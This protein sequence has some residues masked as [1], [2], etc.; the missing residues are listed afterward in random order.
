M[1]LQEF[2]QKEGRV[3]LKTEKIFSYLN[4]DKRSNFSKR[5]IQLEID[6]NSSKRRYEPVH[7]S[8]TISMADFRILNSTVSSLD[9]IFK[10]LTIGLLSKYPA[11]YF[12][13]MVNDETKCI[14]EN[15]LHLIACNRN[16]TSLEERAISDIHNYLQVIFNEANDL[17]SKINETTFTKEISSI[18]LVNQ[19]TKKLD[20]I[21]YKDRCT[22]EYAHALFNSDLKQLEL[23]TIVNIN[24]NTI[25][26]TKPIQQDQKV[27][28]EKP[29]II[30]GTLEVESRTSRRIHAKGFYIDANKVT[31]KPFN[32]MLFC[33]GTGDQ[34]EQF[35]ELFRLIDTELS[36]RELT[37]IVKSKQSYVC[38]EG[39][40]SKV[41]HLFS[42]DD[43]TF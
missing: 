31:N 17:I 15:Y 6:Y 4:F 27:F 3:I 38:L 35:E 18:K 28:L 12:D 41:K 43:H 25:T 34:K 14:K 1:N 20:H 13:L 22:A 42:I 11:I 21:V 5:N 32:E 36:G 8:S 9:K 39:I 26:L 16:G 24:S 10:A 7:S 33:K 40:D 30:R 19:N 2:L 37:F 29:H 23:A